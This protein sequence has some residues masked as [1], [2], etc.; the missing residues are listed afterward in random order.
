MSVEEELMGNS[1]ITDFS[2]VKYEKEQ[3]ED[4]FSKQDFVIRPAGEQNVAGEERVR[5]RSGV[6]S[7][8]GGKVS[9]TGSVRGGR[10]EA[11]VVKEEEVGAKKEDVKEDVGMKKKEVK[12]EKPIFAKK[13][14]K[15]DIVIDER[16]R[17][18]KKKANVVAKEKVKPKKEEKKGLS[19]GGRNLL[20]LGVGSIMVAMVTTVLSLIL[21]H[22]S[23]DIYLDR[24]RP[25]FLP[26]KAEETLEEQYMFKDSGIID[27]NVIDEYLKNLRRE[28]KTIESLDNPYGAEPLSDE[29]L[30]IPP[31]SVPESTEEPVPEG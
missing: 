6:R 5:G 27:G 24:S 1:Q 7:V 28:R 25:G 17:K 14:K 11:K 26:E 31:E 8:R 30:G 4:F 22:N 12:E 18:A 10:V 29:S 9:G 19:R 21:Y 20:W 13:R 2:K 3:K 15:A 23:G 16:P